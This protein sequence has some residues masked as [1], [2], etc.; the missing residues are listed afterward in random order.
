MTQSIAVPIEVIVKYTEQGQIRPV[1]VIFADEMFIIDR[2]FT[3]KVV[4]PPWGGYSVYEFACLLKG[5][6]KKIYFDKQN[7]KWF[8]SK[9]YDCYQ[10]YMKGGVGDV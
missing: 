2:V 5:K 1:K 6:R 7:S 4:Q 3:E 8:V 9:E 10:N